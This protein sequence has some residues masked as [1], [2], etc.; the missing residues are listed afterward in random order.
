MGIGPAAGID[1]YADHAYLRDGRNDYRGDGRGGAY[2][3][4]RD[5][6]LQNVRLMK[7]LTGKG[8]GCGADHEL[9]VDP[10]D[11]TERSFDE[12]KKPEK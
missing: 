7:A 11:M 8:A 2:D 4:T 9:S 6:F 10:K 5:W 3:E 12:S 1:E